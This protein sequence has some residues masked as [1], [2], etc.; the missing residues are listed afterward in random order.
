MG[1]LCKKA[2][3]K[4]ALTRNQE[5]EPWPWTSSLQNYE[6]INFCWLNHSV[7]SNLTITYVIPFFSFDLTLY[8]L[9]RTQSLSPGH[10]KLCCTASLTIWLPVT[11]TLKKIF[12]GS[13]HDGTAETNLTRNHEVAGSILASLSGLRTQHCCEL[14]Y[15]SQARLGAGI[16][17]AVT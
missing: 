6:N 9:P 8:C 5:L 10:H 3:R 11:K 7:Y 15:R 12:H 2:A 14:W 17:V 13:S 16:A 4:R 1:G